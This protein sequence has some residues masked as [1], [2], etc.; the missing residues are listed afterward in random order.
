MSKQNNHKRYPSDLTEAQWELLAPLYSRGFTEHNPGDDS[1]TGNHER[2][3]LRA[4]NRLFVKT[5]AP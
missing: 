2:H 1:A 5:D 3:S 4:A